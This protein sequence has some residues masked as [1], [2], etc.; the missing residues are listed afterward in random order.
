MAAK[1]RWGR[2]MKLANFVNTQILFSPINWII[3]IGVATIVPLAVA[4]IANPPKN[5]TGL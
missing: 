1:D 5:P 2:A 3:I 4:A